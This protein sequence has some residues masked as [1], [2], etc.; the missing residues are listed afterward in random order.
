MSIT[1]IEKERES[2]IVERSKVKMKVLKHEVMLEVYT[3][4]L[5]ILD[6]Q[7]TKMEETLGFDAPE[8]FPDKF[9]ESYNHYGNKA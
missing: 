2:A 1:D 3:K 8:R 9:I 4:E 5:A 7:I 6:K